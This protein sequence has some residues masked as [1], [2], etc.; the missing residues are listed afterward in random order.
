MKNKT[1]IFLNLFQS[2][3]PDC[4]E[5]VRECFLDFDNYYYILRGDFNIALNQALDTQNHSH[6]YNSNAKEK[7]L[8]IM[9]D[10]S[11]D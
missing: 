8:E 4:F 7:L 3:S 5:K 2:I 11:F 6:V 9:S 10:L 1:N